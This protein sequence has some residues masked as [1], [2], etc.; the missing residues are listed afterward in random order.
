MSFPAAV[1]HCKI[2]LYVHIQISFQNASMRLFQQLQ[3][4]L[5]WNTAKSVPERGG[6]WR[7]SPPAALLAFLVPAQ[8]VSGECLLI[9]PNCPTDFSGIPLK[10]FVQK[11]FP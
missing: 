2:Y 11:R 3:G 6:S 9:S 5:N 10:P 8:L 1:I 4:S 7:E